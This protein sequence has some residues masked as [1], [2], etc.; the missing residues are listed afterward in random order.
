MPVHSTHRLMTPFDPSPRL[1]NPAVPRANILGVGISAINLTEGTRLILDAVRE[2]RKGY[3]AVT[4]VHGVSEAQYDPELRHILNSAFLN[5]PDGMP[6]TLAAQPALDRCWCR[7]TT[8]AGMDASRSIRL[9][10]HFRTLAVPIRTT[11]GMV[12]GSGRRR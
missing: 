6:M 5:T 3:V 11:E 2:K 10:V 4:G 12:M 1:D 8:S 9:L 7:T